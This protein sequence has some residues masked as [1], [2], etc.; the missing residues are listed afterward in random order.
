[1]KIECNRIVNNNN[2]NNT[3]KMYLIQKKREDKKKKHVKPKYS[4][5]SKAGGKGGCDY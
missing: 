3:F 4:I 5:M 1:M 2:N